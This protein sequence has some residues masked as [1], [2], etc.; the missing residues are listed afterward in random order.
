MGLARE[1][2]KCQR[3]EGYSKMGAENLDRQPR[4]LSRDPKSPV[5]RLTEIRRSMVRLIH[6]RVFRWSIFASVCCAL[7]ALGAGRNKGSGPD[8]NG[9][10]PSVDTDQEI[11]RIRQEFGVRVHVNFDPASY[12]PARWRS[13][14]VSANGVQIEPAAAIQV[15]NII[16]RFLAMYPRGLIAGNLR[17]IYLLKSMSFYGSI[18][19]GTY[20]RDAIYVAN[21][22]EDH[23]DTDLNLLALMHSEFSSILYRNYG[24]PAEEWSRINES[25]WRYLGLDKDLLGQPNLFQ[26]TDDLLSKGFTSVYSQA[27][28]EEDVNM[29]VFSV[30]VSE[31]SLVLAARTHKRVKQKLE[32]L[33]RFYDRIDRQIHTSERFE[34]LIRL[35]SV[36]DPARHVAQPPI[37]IAKER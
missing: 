36:L 14:P 28:L 27:S 37:L 17:N 18:Y 9:I 31:D 35:K 19:W 33:T 20:R 13:A 32:L 6:V 2:I 8:P 3:G 10:R 22:G 23:V 30:I 7:F 24:F 34:F 15:K 1:S 29:Y 16:P 25:S 4:K 5:R 12:F 26:V 11:A 21:S